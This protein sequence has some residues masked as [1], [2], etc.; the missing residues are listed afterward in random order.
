M[1]YA[2]GNANYRYDSPL[3]LYLS[4]PADSNH[5]N[6]FRLNTLLNNGEHFTCNEDRIRRVMH[7]IQPLHGI[8]Q[9]EALC[10]LLNVTAM[11]LI[12]NMWSDRAVWNTSASDWQLFDLVGSVRRTLGRFE[13]APKQR[14]ST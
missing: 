9:F 14:H 6:A 10:F 8:A 7:R 13:R 4:S 3:Q 2:I 11:P 1:T 12:R 5:K